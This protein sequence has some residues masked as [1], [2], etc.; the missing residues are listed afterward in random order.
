M[1]NTRIKVQIVEKSEV[2]EGIYQFTFVPE[3]GTV[4]PAFNAGAHID[5]VLDDRTVRQ[6][7]LINGPD[8]SSG[9]QIAVLRDTGGRGGSVKLCDEFD[10]GD[11]LEISEPRNLFPLQSAE[12]YILIAG[13]IGVT[14]IYA[15]AKQ[16]AAQG[17]SF[18]FH[19]LCRSREKAAFR[20]E[21]QERFFDRFRLH[22]DDGEQ[23]FDADRV[24]SMPSAETRLFICGPA[25]LIG[26]IEERALSLGWAKERI[27]Y[28]LFNRSETSQIEESAAFEIVVSGSG[29]VIS[30]GAEETALEALLRNGFD[31]LCSCEQGVCGSC[32]LEVVEGEPDHRDMF[33]TD[34]E[35][36]QN[37]VFT[38]CCSR[39]LSPRLTLVV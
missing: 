21:L 35:R 38:P 4:L 28:E 7:S 23:R 29:E 24:L 6:Y 37:R 33:L 19:Y 22:L 14:P 36:A 13:G 18:E 12:H 10:R 27:H 26:F 16:L 32:V 8:Q 17:A 15:M 30:V 34:E 3:S 2:A 20:S 25:G 9:Y 5:V 1:S 39:S 11:R 31:V